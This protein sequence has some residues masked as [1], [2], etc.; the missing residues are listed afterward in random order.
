MRRFS[1]SLS[2]SSLAS[3]GV[4]L[5]YPMK[6]TSSESHDRMPLLTQFIRQPSH[7]AGQRRETSVNIFLVDHRAIQAIMD[8]NKAGNDAG[9]DAVG[10]KRKKNAPDGDGHQPQKSRRVLA[11]DTC[12]RIK[13]RCDFDVTAGSCNRCKN[14]RYVCDYSLSVQLIIFVG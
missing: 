5:M 2:V 4:T 1:L 10:S 3:C 11:C 8:L 13:S 7:S 6:A 12:R 14:L 9:N